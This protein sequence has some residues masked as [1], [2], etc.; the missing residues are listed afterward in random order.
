MLTTSSQHELAVR[1]RELHAGPR[2]L[3]LANAWDVTS[4]RVLAAAGASAIGT[5][6]FGVALDNGV[7]DGERLPFDDVLDVASAITAAVDVPV[8]VDL[9]AGR[10]ST[11]DEVEPDP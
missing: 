5:T 10:G 9:E 2:P 1:F 4:A 3:L 6:S 11:P 8:T 7:M